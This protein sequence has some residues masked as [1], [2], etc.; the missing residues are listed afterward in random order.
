MLIK[1]SNLP[2]PT[3]AI[4]GEIILLCYPIKFSVDNFSGNSFHICVVFHNQ[5]DLK[6]V[7]SIG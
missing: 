5:F 3:Y 6:A 7:K 4:N 1:E 2:K